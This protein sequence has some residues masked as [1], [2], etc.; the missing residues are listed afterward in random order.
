MTS[1]CHQPAPPVGASGSCTSNA[2]LFVPSGARDQESSGEMFW[3][4]QPK[5]L[6]TCSSWIRPFGL[7]SLLVSVNRARA[8]ARLRTGLLADF[9]ADFRVDFLAAMAVLLDDEWTRRMSIA[10]RA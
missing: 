1:Q 10:S 7:K 6:N 3:P 2:K 9:V 5:P 4:W 8:A